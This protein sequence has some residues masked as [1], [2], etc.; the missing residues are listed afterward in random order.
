MQ[1]YDSNAWGCGAT[2]QKKVAEY[3]Q[4]VNPNVHVHSVDLAGYGTSQFVGK[5]T[6]LVAGWSE[7]VFDFCKMAEE[8]MDSLVKTI[9][10]YK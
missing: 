10:T 2:A 5:D 9:A 7:K 6:T 8:G 3:K 1:A 4:K